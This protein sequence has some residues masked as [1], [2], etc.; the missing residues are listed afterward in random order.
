[1]REE[2]QAEA[3]LSQTRS[4]AAWAKL[5]ISCFGEAGVEQG[6]RN[7]MLSGGLLAGPE[8]SLVVDVHAV[9]NGVE[10]AGLS[11]RIP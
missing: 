2:R 8:V 10:S 11:G 3:G 9:G 7:M 5:R 6:R 4:P 1:M